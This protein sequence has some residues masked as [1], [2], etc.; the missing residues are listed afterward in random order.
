VTLLRQLVASVVF[1]GGIAS[2]SPA[3]NARI[4]REILGGEDARTELLEVTTARLGPDTRIYVAER[5][6]RDIRVFDSNGK[7]VRNIGR[8]GSGPG[9]FR[10]IQNFGFIA[11]TLWVIDPALRRTSFFSITGQLIRTVPYP[12]SGPGRAR[13]HNDAMSIAG[14]LVQP[15]VPY[16]SGESSPLLRMSLEGAIHDTIA[17]LRLDHLMASF[18][19][20]NFGFDLVEPFPDF[21]LWDLDSSGRWLAIADRSVAAG[22]NRA[23][24]PLQVTDLQLRGNRTFQIAYQPTRVSPAMVDSAL[25]RFDE[26]LRRTGMT[27]AQLAKY[28]FVP[29]FVPPVAAV[30]TS[31]DGSVWLA[32]DEK[33][34]GSTWISVDQAGRTQ[35]TVVVPPGYRVRDA[36]GE[37]LVATLY[38]SDREQAPVVL[39]SLRR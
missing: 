8:I 22:S 33:S 10:E 4:V 6:H 28:F 35:N 34:T 3:Q 30:V 25:R 12:T 2:T 13:G 38:D 19:H 36:S 37:T 15:S 39:I 32:R 20:T 11:D 27:R 23:S 5:K 1:A 31:S 7:F 17:V 9:E 21:A 18:K 14:R 26:V 24:F 16:R 29:E